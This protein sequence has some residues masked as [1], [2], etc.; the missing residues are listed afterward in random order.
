MSEKFSQRHGY[1]GQAR[2]ITVRQEAPPELR[3]AITRM[4]RDAGM[5]PKEI[6]KVVCRDLYADPSEL[7]L[8]DS[9]IMKEVDELLFDCE[10]FRVYDF[11]ESFHIRLGLP[12]GGGVSTSI[13]SSFEVAR[14][15]ARG[16][17]TRLNRYFME[18]GIGWQM[19]D[20]KI[21]HRGS[22]A[23]ERATQRAVEALD[24]SGRQT[25]K[26]QMEEALRDI[27]RRP[28][29]D[30]T[31]AITHALAGL[32]CVARDVTGKPN[33]TLGK[34]I[35]YLNLTPPLDKAVHMVW[36]F[37]SER[38]RHIR[39]GQSVSTEE[40]ELVVHVACALCTFLSGDTR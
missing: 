2:E 19:S 20:G 33:L 36:G 3:K 38:A 18:H 16:F 17:E 25:A 24:S 12:P 13:T 22:D 9:Y 26:D 35:P 27:S 5:S 1:A 14:A 15:K 29:P 34:L 32:E 37:S 31:G 28:E 4:A 10:W 11:A 23:Y 21:V 8:V 30:V 7:S 6:R 39:E 40:A